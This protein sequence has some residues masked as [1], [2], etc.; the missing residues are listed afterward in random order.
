[1]VAITEDIFSQAVNEADSDHY[2]EED[3]FCVG[4][5]WPLVVTNIR[6]AH[7]LRRV[8]CCKFRRILRLWGPVVD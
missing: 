6:V 4:V 1:M 3:S 5:S 8:D 7:C 2:Y